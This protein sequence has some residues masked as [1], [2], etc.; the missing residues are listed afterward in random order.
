MTNSKVLVVLGMMGRCP[1]GGQTW[2]YINWLRGLKRLGHRVYYVED[3]LDWPYDPRV[4]TCHTDPEYTVDYIRGVLGRIGLEDHWAYRPRYRSANEC[5]GMTVEQLRELYRSCDAMLNIC[6]AAAI[7]WNPEQQVARR[8]IL[9]ETDPVGAELEIANGNEGTLEVYLPHDTFVTYG[10]NYGAPDCGVPV[11]NFHFLKTRQPIDTD[12][13]PYSFDPSCTKYTTSGNWKQ[14]GRDIEYNGELYY[15]S[16]HHEFL[17][18]IDL[19]RLRPGID[20]ELCMNIDERDEADRLLLLEHGW[21]LSSPFQMSLD[22]WGYQNYFK[23]AR[24]EYTC[25][26]DQNV[27]LRSGWFSERDLCFLASGKP[28]IAQETGFSNFF[29]CGEGLFAFDTMDQ[30][31]A[32]IDTIESDYEKACRAAREIAVE[33]FDCEKVCR[34]LIEDINL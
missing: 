13:W 33:Y 7:G 4:N 29:P 20:F 17:K 32:A 25:A 15:W 27:R 24:A 1:F 19:P 26:K 14:N 2:L 16:K 21:R 11:G 12:L 6:G 28:V 22:P 10:E 9:I 3:D 18:F 23:R 5:Y 34:K 30:I 31:L 8:K